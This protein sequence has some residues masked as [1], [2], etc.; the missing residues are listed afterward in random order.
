MTRTGNPADFAA[1]R[2]MPSIVTRPTR[3]RAL[4]RPIRWLR[5]P[6][7]MQISQVTAWSFRDK[8]EV[9]V[10][11]ANPEV[12]HRIQNPDSTAIG[13]VPKHGIFLEKPAPAINL[14]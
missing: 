4:S 7:R 12:E 11:Q 14:P 6:A 3:S 2:T 10:R 13:N 5:P 8:G 1:L 9:S